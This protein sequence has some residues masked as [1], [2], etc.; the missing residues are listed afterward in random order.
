LGWLIEPGL[1]THILL[2][3]ARDNLLPPAPANGTNGSRQVTIR[4]ST[5]C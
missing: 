2:V 1:L 4:A 3:A 5:H